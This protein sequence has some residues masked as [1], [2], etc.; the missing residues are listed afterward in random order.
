MYHEVSDDTERRKRTRHTNPAYSLSVEQFREQMQYIHDNGY[1]TWS[2]NELL[3]TK[4]H[5]QQKSVTLT[6]DD[7]WQNNHTHA[8]PIL[9]EFGLTATIFVITDFVSQ[10]NY[11]DCE[12]LREMKTQGISIQSHT[13]MHSPLTGL[14]T[15]E[16][17]RELE[18]S[19]HTIEHHLGT[20]VDFLSAPHGMIDEKVLDI[21]GSIGYKAVCTSEPGFS[22]SH[23]S[24][25][26]L[27]RINISNRCDI[28]TFGKILEG[29][30][31]SILPARISKK[32]K[33]LT[34]KLV[35]YNNYRKLYNLRY[36]I[37][38]G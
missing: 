24:P 29:N 5:T 32:T 17:K 27:K 35:G 22:H 25:A 18:V 33:N 6:F 7:G 13:A 37:R 8:F 4:S 26:I 11:L 30:Q 10:P 15:S 3:D 1:R 28:S 9:E 21:A 12:Q 16:I 36:R 23:G 20:P 38:A 2:L 14:A 34:K 31:L 19:K